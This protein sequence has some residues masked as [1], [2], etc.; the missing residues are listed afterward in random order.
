MKKLYID[1]DGV[2]LTSKQKRTADN[3]VLLIDFVTTNYDC[4]W[5]T[6]HC[7]GDISNPIAYLAKYY[8]AK[9]VDILR[10]IKPTNWSTLKTEAIDFASDFLWLDDYALDAEKKVLSANSSLDK[11]ITVNLNNVDE[12]KNVI[13]I[14]VGHLKKI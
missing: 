8:D 14:L 12:L 5:L 9:T 10:R 1:I 7:K 11:L 4:Y 3:A 13:T 2:L 6:T